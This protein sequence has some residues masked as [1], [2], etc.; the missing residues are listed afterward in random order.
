MTTENLHELTAAYALDALDD[1]ERA[2][3]EAHLRECGE[4]RAELASLSETVGVLALAND[5]PSPSAGLRDRIVSAARAEAPKV[6]AL[7]P[8][9]T[10][11]YAATAVAAAAAVGLAIGLSLALTGGPSGPRLALKLDGGRPA[12]LTASGFDSIPSESI[13]EIWVIRSGTP[14][15]A[16]YFRGGEKVTVTLTRPVPAGSTVA[17]TLERAP[18]ATKPTPPI[19]ASTTV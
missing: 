13:Y 1:D 8:R 10:R 12:Q 7:R 16:G 5:G 3:Y 2:S 19:L 4:C 9:R 11:F 17:V 18:G 6:V 15:P 14:R